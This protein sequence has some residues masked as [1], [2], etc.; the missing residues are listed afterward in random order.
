MAAMDTTE[1]WFVRYRLLEGRAP[2]DG[3]PDTRQ[4]VTLD[5]G[6][7][8]R[9]LAELVL[10]DTSIHGTIPRGLGPVEVRGARLV[11]AG[12]AWLYEPA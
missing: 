4:E 12:P 9:Y 2:V 5:E 11:S 6:P 1:L 8:G 3:E 7:F 10:A